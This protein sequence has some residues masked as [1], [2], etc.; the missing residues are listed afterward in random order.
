MG[1]TASKSEIRALQ[2]KVIFSL[3]KQGVLFDGD[4]I[5]LPGDIDKEGIRQLHHEAVQTRIERSKEG[6]FRREARLLSYIA[7]GE[8]VKPAKISPLLTQVAP[9]T[10]WECNYPVKD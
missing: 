10:E 7:A 6:L 8:E 1:Y 9:D 3:E 2:N 5:N 4:K